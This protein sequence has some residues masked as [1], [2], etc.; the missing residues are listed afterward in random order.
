MG[1]TR[2]NW[3][4]MKYFKNLNYDIFHITLFLFIC[5]M[6]FCAIFVNLID[7]GVVLSIHQFNI[8]TVSVMGMLIFGYG[9]FGMIKL[10]KMGYDWFEIKKR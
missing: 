5:Y 6:I 2:F 3:N 9:T 10:M 8:K 7:N 4:P 1:R